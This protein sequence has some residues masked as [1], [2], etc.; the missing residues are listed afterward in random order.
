MPIKWSALKV[1]DAM[2]ML[3]ECINQAI[4][5]LE[6]ARIIADEAR[7]IPNLPQYVEQH[8]LR[9]IGEINRAIGGNGN[10]KEG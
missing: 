2:D 4:E 6:Q 10:R 5:P 9:I 1:N 8:L 7:N 3:E